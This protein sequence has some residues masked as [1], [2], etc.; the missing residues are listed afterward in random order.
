MSTTENFNVYKGLPYQVRAR[1]VGQ[2][3]YTASQTFTTE[4]QA[5]NV[6]MTA[7][8]GLDMGYE[9]SYQSADKVDFSNTVLPW[10][11][12]YST[13]LLTNRYCLMPVGTTY[14]NVTWLG[15]A[16]NF[17]V[18]GSPTINDETKVVSGFS[19]SNM[20]KLSDLTTSISTFEICIKLKTTS[21]STDQTFV[22]YY[23]T[24]SNRFYSPQ[25]NIKNDGTLQCNISFDGTSWGISGT[26]LQSTNALSAD[27][28]YWIKF[29]FDGTDYK[30][31]VSTDGTTYTEWA[32]YTSSSAPYGMKGM[33]W[34]TGG[35]SAIFQSLSGEIDLSES[36]IKVNGSDW[37]VPT[38]TKTAKQK[39]NPNI[40]N[41]G[42]VS[43]DRDFVASGFSSSQYLSATATTIEGFDVGNSVWICKFRIG[44]SI[45]TSQILQSYFVLQIVQSGYGGYVVS[46]NNNTSSRVD[47][48]SL[49]SGS[50]NTDYW[51]KVV[52]SGSSRTFY[53][54]TNG[55]TW[56]QCYQNNNFEI[57]SGSNVSI[58]YIGYTPWSYAFNGTVDL[59]ELK[60]E[61]GNG[62]VVWKGVVETETLS[63]C[64]YNF[65]DDGSATTLNA[66]AVN[67][68]ESVVLTPDNSYTNGWLLG[69]V[70]I[71]QHTVYS[72]NNGTWTEA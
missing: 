66:F 29:T 51:V 64:T 59:K 61:D 48:F 34:G 41:T 30:I 40:T 14:E 65:T 19:D 22:G 8:D 70:S 1:A 56:T 47:L 25:F 67:G 17:D 27:T 5:V 57:I 42:D 60:V 2:Y 37:F 10:K 49:S 7:Y 9:E 63:G 11:W 18:I 35:S 24:G 44:P 16:Y 46:W 23:T 33:S 15:Y 13:A 38:F 28:W 68:D 12:Q 21:V 39:L 69:T 36:Y 71:P 54:S 4:G 32:S 72:Y 58:Q 43:I 45:K 6:S 55:T 50:I 20:I 31:L 26:S 62:N 53:Y 3:D 52:I